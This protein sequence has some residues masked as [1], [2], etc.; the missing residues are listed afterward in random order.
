ME[1]E[2]IIPPDL[3]PALAGLVIDHEAGRKEAY[4]AF[5]DLVIRGYVSPVISSNKKAFA[6]A[7]KGNGVLFEHEKATL[8]AVFQSDGKPVKDLKQKPVIFSLEAKKGVYNLRANRIGFSEPSVVVAYSD[9]AK[10]LDNFGIDDKFQHVLA[11]DAIKQGLYVKK[12]MPEDLLFYGACREVMSGYEEKFLPELSTNL[13]S[14]QMMKYLDLLAW[15]KE[16][17]LHEVR[18]SNEYLGYA[19]AFG[20]IKNYKKFPK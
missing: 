14:A 16:R 6:I 9:A 7:D 19:I 20:L 13:G 17:P 5:V 4:A 1:N 15:L 8:K 12:E 18:W 10:A 3:R 2:A 11:E